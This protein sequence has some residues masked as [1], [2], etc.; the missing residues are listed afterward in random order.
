MLGDLREERVECARAERRLEAGGVGR[1]L[2][3]LG[4][5]LERNLEL[6]T[7]WGEVPAYAA[8]LETTLGP[9]ALDPLLAQVAEREAA[10]IP[11]ARRLFAA[12]LSL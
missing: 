2:A 3:P 7:E 6:A 9:G 11:L 5:E 1:D 8:S 10:M 12:W 4:G